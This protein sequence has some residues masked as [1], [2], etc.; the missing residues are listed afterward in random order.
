M[1]VK[2]A[3]RFATIL[4]RWLGSCVLLASDKTPAGVVFGDTHVGNANGR[5]SFGHCDFA[6]CFCDDF[7][8]LSDNVLRMLYD[9]AAQP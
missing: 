1:T 8:S 4:W 2:A 7:G 6:W 5:H 3:P 9:D